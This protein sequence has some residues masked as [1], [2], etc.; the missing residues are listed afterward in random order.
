MAI[1]GT[2][3]CIADLKDERFDVQ[4]LGFGLMSTYHAL[5]ER[6]LLSDFATGF[7]VLAK[8]VNNMDSQDQHSTK[9]A[10]R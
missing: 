1:T 8:I 3:P 9:R 5:N 6:A 10:K 2:L 7:R 4:T